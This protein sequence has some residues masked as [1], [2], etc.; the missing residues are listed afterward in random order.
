MLTES[1]RK[2]AIFLDRDGTIIRDVGYLKIPDQIEF[3]SG[4]IDGLRKLKQA[5]FPL[6][7]VTNQSGV[8]RGYFTEENVR[9]TNDSLQNLLAKEGADLDAVYYCPYLAEGTI[10]KY[11]IDSDLRKPKPGM[12]LKAAA[13]HHLILERSYMIGDSPSDIGAGKAAGCRT[14]L[15]L[16]DSHDRAMMTE[17]SHADLSATSIDEA[18]DL[19]LSEIEAQ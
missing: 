7:L 4:S 3:L 12:L 11:A 19:I 10:K 18:A 17:A 15:I 5:G 6:I 8:A 16:Q 9:R 13:E 1:N 2:P 14:I